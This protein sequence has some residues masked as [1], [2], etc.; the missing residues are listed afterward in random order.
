ME[1]LA[2]KVYG[3]IRQQFEAERE[4]QNYSTTA[5]LPWFDAVSQL[6]A[7]P[8]RLSADATESLVPIDRHFERL[9]REIRDRLQER[10]NLDRERSSW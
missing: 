5:S 10:I 2:R 3:L 4:R 9:V 8:D 1:G 6:S 7:H